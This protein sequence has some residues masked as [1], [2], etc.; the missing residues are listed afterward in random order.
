MVEGV[1][2]LVLRL[3][4]RPA[5]WGDDPFAWNSA[6]SVVSRLEASKRDG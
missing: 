5:R 1:S 3:F 4:H 2:R 6:P